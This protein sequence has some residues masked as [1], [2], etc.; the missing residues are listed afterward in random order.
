MEF[1]D[2][3]IP[4]HQYVIGADF[5]YGIQGRDYDAAV[6]LDATEFMR[7]GVA[8]QVC[9]MHGHWGEAFHTLLY[10]CIRYWN[11]A[12]LLGERQV[13][14]MCLRTLYDRYQWRWMY[15]E[16][17]LE[18]A[19]AVEDSAMRLGYHKSGNDY[20]VARLREA[21]RIKRLDL[22]STT[23]VEQLAKVQWRGSTAEARTMEREP[24]ERLKMKLSGGGSPDLAWACGY[25]NLALE[26]VHEFEQERPKLPPGSLG[27]IAGLPELLPEVY[28]SSNKS[29]HWH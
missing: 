26:C 27:M 14:L 22:R 28:G 11:G 19:A 17:K 9:E 2:D 1:W 12:F 16:K 23:L 13:G 25:A 8:P 20:M 15:Y 29:P 6:V 5:A 3:P 18:N 24:D 21:V 4:G 7:T 10:A